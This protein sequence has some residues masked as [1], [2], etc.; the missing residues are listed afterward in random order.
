MKA[1][2]KTPQHLTSKRLA[3]ATAT[4]A[5]GSPPLCPVLCAP[6]LHARHRKWETHFILRNDMQSVEQRLCQ[7]LGSTLTPHGGSG[8]RDAL[9]G[10]PGWRA[11]G[12]GGCG[13]PHPKPLGAQQSSNQT[14]LPGPDWKPATGQTVPSLG[15]PP[16]GMYLR[17]SQKGLRGEFP[18][19]ADRQTDRLTPQTAP[20]TEH[21]CLP[22][23]AGAESLHKPTTLR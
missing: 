20:A 1:S 18:R 2:K 16:L 11:P 23:G 7:A 3:G 21:R 19:Q 22:P 10:W 9:R 17:N 4:M 5:G 14:A 15:W 12:P 6:A 13:L 8:A